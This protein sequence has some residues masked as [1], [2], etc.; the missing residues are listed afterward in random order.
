MFVHFSFS[1]CSGLSAVSGGRNR[2]HLYFYFFLLTFTFSEASLTQVREY[3]SFL[4]S[5]FE[6]KVSNYTSDVYEQVLNEKKEFAELVRSVLWSRFEICCTRMACLDIFPGRAFI[7]EHALAGKLFSFVLLLYALSNLG[8]L[9][10]SGNRFIVLSNLF[11]VALIFWYY[12]SNRQPG[13]IN[14]IAV[15]SMPALALYFLISVR[16]G[17]DMMGV[18]MLVG[19]PVTAIFF[20]R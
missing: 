1:S 4:P 13:W 12:H 8:S 5:I 11:A 14:R 3:L 10:P 9:I 15:L 17:L 2:K 18:Q 7:R 19:N 16:I 6:A 20:Q